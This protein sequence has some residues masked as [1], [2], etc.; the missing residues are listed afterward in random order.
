M[1]HAGNNATKLYANAEAAD[2]YTRALSLAKKLPDD[3]QGEILATLHGKRGASNM[4]LSRFG[5]SIDDFVKMLKYQ[6]VQNS[7]EAGC[8]A[9][10]NGHVV[11][12]LSSPRR[13]GSL[14]RSGTVA[15]KK[16][17][18][19]TLRLDTMGLMALKHAALR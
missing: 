6:E 3:E 10:R 14:C 2:H 17:G 7:P 19:E 11:V 13:N 15:A 8:R 12:L 18:S 4:A 1:T 5:D 9:K 16:A